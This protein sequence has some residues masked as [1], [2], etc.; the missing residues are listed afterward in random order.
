MNIKKFKFNHEVISIIRKESFGTNW[1]VVYIINDDS[2]YYI[3]ETTHV[4][5]RVAQHLKN[6]DKN[7]LKIFRVINDDDFNKSATLDIESSLIKFFSAEGISLQN[8]NGGLSEH[9]YFD[10]EKYQ[11]MF[12]NIWEELKKLGIVKK[13][14]IQL[15]NTDLFKYSPYKALTSDQFDVADDILKDIRSQFTGAI[16]VSG[17]PGTGKSILA[18]YLIKYLKDSV[19]FKHLNIA[20]VVPMTSFRNTLKKV[21]RNVKNLSSS[22]VIGPNDVVKK[23]YDLLFVDEAHRLKQRKNLTNYGSFDSVN[24]QLGLV[25]GSQLDWIKNSSK[26]QILFYDAHQSIHPSDADFSDFSF[27]KEY[28]LNS[29]VRVRGGDKYINFIEHFLGEVPVLPDFENYDFKLF[30]S[31]NELVLAIRSKESGVDGNFKGLSRLLAGYAWEWISKKDPTKFDIVVGDV[32]LKWNSV[33][34][35]WANSSNAFA[36]VGCIHTIQGYDLNYAGVIIGPELSYDFEKNELVVFKNKYKDKKGK[37]AINTVE[38]LKRYILNI[39]R[40]LLTRGVYGTYIYI[41]DDDLRTYFKNSLKTENLIEYGLIHDQSLAVAE[42]K[43][44]YGS[45]K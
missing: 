26:Q 32:K 9:N 31:L 21:F 37:A 15:K 33:A 10:K 20:L 1:P 6:P 35:D 11:V 44:D 14:L 41:C 45:D 4:H 19:D 39:Y 2:Q 34:S 13:D 36:E 25:N 18:V 30:D 3:G 43:I 22:M 27:V 42:K 8:G 29:Q 7:K 17:S 24:R 16:K 28:A 5:T 40:V 38:Q 23:E 12:E